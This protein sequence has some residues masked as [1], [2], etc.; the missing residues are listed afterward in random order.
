MLLLDIAWPPSPGPDGVPFWVYLSYF[1]TVDPPYRGWPG[2]EWPALYQSASDS[3]Y[4]P[5]WPGSA[6]KLCYLLAQPAQ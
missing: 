2:I 4:R 6:A 3:V 1:V 5:L